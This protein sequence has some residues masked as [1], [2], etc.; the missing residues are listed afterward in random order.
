ME[1]YKVQ[2][3]FLEEAKEF[4]DSLDVKA[5][6]KIVYN[7]WKSRI[8]NDKELFKKLHDEIWEFRTKYKRIYY[9]LIAFRIKQTRTTH[10]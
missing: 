1:E 3:K 10:L 4:L 5:R 2:V 9:R 7:I 6:E 8:T